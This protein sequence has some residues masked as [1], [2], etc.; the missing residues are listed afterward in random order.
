MSDPVEHNPFAAP[1]VNDP[2][3]ASTGQID[4]V[5]LRPVGTGLGVI[6][7]SLILIV[8]SAIGGLAIASLGGRMGGGWQQILVVALV[9]IPVLASILSLVGGIM[10]LSVPPD[11]GH[12][13]VLSSVVLQGIQLM[14]RLGSFFFGYVAIGG[15]AF[16]TPSLLGLPSML[17]VA[18][19]LLF[20]RRL[21]QFLQRNDLARR[22]VRVLV[23]SS[24]MF[25]GGLIGP[26]LL[27]GV[28][29][30]PILAVFGVA[31]IVLFVM[32]A[33]LINAL[34]KAIRHPE[35]TATNHLG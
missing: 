35:Q 28:P 12:T 22:A 27:S 2:L 31:A 5:A 20:L 30:T 4:Y 8:L 19:F 26:S 16:M 29:A 32:Y 13:L 11:C 7:A 23:A 25:V 14:I 21:A 9:G 24:V 1:R 3:V 6:Y 33:N 34:G 17:S 15:L 10:C 18:L